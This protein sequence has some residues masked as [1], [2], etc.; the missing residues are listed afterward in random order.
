MHMGVV[1]NRDMAKNVCEQLDEE[2]WDFI[3]IVY[4]NVQDLESHGRT[5]RGATHTHQFLILSRK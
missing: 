3:D 2:K 1:K 5:A 4:E